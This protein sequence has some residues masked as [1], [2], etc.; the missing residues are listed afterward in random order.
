MH[1]AVLLQ[2]GRKP[3][4]DVLPNVVRKPN[5]LHRDRAAT[6]RQRSGDRRRALVADLIWAE[7]APGL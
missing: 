1:R 5:R 7:T 3:L 4:F 2:R 6:E